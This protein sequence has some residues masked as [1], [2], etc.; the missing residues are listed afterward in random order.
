MWDPVVNDGWKHHTALA[1]GFTLVNESDWQGAVGPPSS[2]I[3]GFPAQMLSPTTAARGPRRSTGIARRLPR[4][5]LTTP[6]DGP[7]KMTYVIGSY[8]SISW[9]EQE[10]R[11]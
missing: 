6:A 7:Y 9:H 1:H 4:P 11:S 2:R 10:Q 8:E 3:Y 5:F